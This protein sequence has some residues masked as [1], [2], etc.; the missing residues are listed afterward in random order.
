M[1]F[2]KQRWNESIHDA[3][4]R[5]ARFFHIAKALR[6]CVELFGCDN[7]RAKNGRESGPFFS[8]V[9]VVLNIPSFA[10]NLQ[11][12]TSTTKQKEVAWRFAGHNGLIIRLNNNDRYYLSVC[13]RF[14]DC[15]WMSC[16]PEEDERIFFA[17]TVK[18]K[19]E[20]IIVVETA[21]NYKQSVAAFHKFDQIL[22]G[23]APYKGNVSQKEY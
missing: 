15:S 2:R 5:N 21:N 7:S 23:K 3:N 1:G 17:S 11:G 18:L 16:F 9:S 22:S 13:V 12:P 4:R 6:E 19:L 20:T 14:W 10:I 8:G